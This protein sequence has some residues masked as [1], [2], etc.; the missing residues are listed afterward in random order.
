MRRFVQALS[1]ETDWASAHFPAFADALR[2]APDRYNIA[3]HDTALAILG[4]S[5]G[6]R[7]REC[8]W[9]LVPP[10][11]PSPQ[12]RY[13]TVTA[14][15]DRAARSRM[16]QRAW[17]SQHCVVPISG[18]YK[19]DRHNAPARPYFIHAR[20]G[21]PLLLA[22]LW[23]CWDR[24]GPALYT[25]T[26]LTGPNPAIPAPLTQDGPVFVPADRWQRWL[27]PSA[28]FPGA[29]LKGLRLPALDAY[30]VG[31]AIQDKTR[32]DYTLLE[33]APVG[34]ESASAHDTDEDFGDDD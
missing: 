27:K 9:G 3:G 11:S 13:T 15:L 20:S 8:V 32:D 23:E 19:W 12:T 6:P 18:Y 22:G 10:W 34:S 24:E 31:R 4:T 25:F 30:P 26:L 16:Y 29:S 17:Q 14:R 7:L 21:E 28:W 5:E 2:A 1:A 33:P